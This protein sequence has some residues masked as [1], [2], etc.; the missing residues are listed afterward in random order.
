MNADLSNER[1][2]SDKLLG[3]RYR[4]IERIGEGGMGVVYRGEHVMISRPV[5]IK[6]L[7]AHFA[8]NEQITERFVREAQAAASIDHPNICAATDFGRTEKDELFLVMEMLEG[9]N[10]KELIERE[11]ALSTARAVSITAQVAS[12]LG[13][14]HARGIIHRDLKP[15]NIFLIE[16]HGEPDFVKVLDFG[17]ARFSDNDSATITNVGDI[18]GTPKY[19]APEQAAAE[20]VDHRVDLY[21]LGVMLY[22]MLT[23]SPPFDSTNSIR[24]IVMH[25]VDPVPSM[26]ER[27]PELDI[28]SELETLVMSLLAKNPGDRPTSTGE[29]LEALR[30]LPLEPSQHAAVTLTPTSVAA[31]SKPSLSREARDILD[32]AGVASMLTKAANSQDEA[33]KPLP[34][35]PPG[36][37]KGEGKGPPT[38]PQKNIDE[39]QPSPKTSSTKATL[40]GAMEGEVGAPLQEATETPSRHRLWAS[41]AVVALLFVV[42]G[43]LLWSGDDGAKKT[44]M[45]ANSTERLGDNTSGDVDAGE[46]KKTIIEEPSPEKVVDK[47]PPPEKVVGKTPPPEKVVDKTP[48]PEKVVDKTPPPVDP[49]RA[50]LDALTA[51]IEALRKTPEIASA[52]EQTKSDDRD[53]AMENLSLLLKLGDAEPENDALKVLVAEGHASGGRDVD[54]I[55]VLNTLLLRRPDLVL[56]VTIR[57]LMMTLFSRKSNK[58]AYKAKKFVSGFMMVPEVS[59]SLL[60]VALSAY[61]INARRRAAKLLEKKNQL[62]AHPLWVQTGVEL[63]GVSKGKCFEVEPI[64]IRLLEQS[65]KASLSML[66]MIHADMSNGCGPKGQRPCC[67]LLM[68]PLEARIRELR[69]TTR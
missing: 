18:M 51:D 27:K 34:L 9:Q 49:L 41:I 17:L 32:F 24:V 5:A 35:P 2:T 52:L 6:L 59:A 69:S 58:L 50:E 12:A 30:A 16:R 31:C 22:E 48:P 15:E 25:M 60:D 23:G 13:S 47:T 56:N 66:E 61:Y 40:Q 62:Q 19:M 45:N 29:I 43:L 64:L 33:A 53:V 65:V 36:E 3:G 57:D 11:G 4:L 68:P 44:E 42:V 28:D 37:Y 14:A 8:R 38:I 1:E 21:A 67:V 7:R 10:L 54:A 55:E 39:L 63:R 46:I 20:T 26:W